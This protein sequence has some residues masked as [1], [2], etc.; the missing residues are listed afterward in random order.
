MPANKKIKTDNNN[1]IFQDIIDYEILRS[2]INYLLVI[3]KNTSNNN[4]NNNNQYI[5][6]KFYLNIN[7]ILNYTLVSKK[8]YNFISL[9]ISNNIIDNKSF[10]HWLKIDN[11]INNKSFTEVYN[12]Q[13]QYDK[14][15]LILNN[16]K[17]ISFNKEFSIIKIK[18]SIIDDYFK[19]NLILNRITID[20][21]KEI[22]NKFKNNQ[23]LYNKI[24]IYFQTDYGLP[25]CI[26][27]S[28]IQEYVSNE[29]PEIMTNLFKILELNCNI[30]LDN[31]GYSPNSEEEEE[32]EENKGN[33]KCSEIYL[34]HILVSGFDRGAIED[35]ETVKI[36]KIFK[37][38]NLV[39]DASDIEVESLSHVNY[40]A[41]FD[42]DN[43]GQQVESI[44]VKVLLEPE[45]EEFVEARHLM[46]V[47]QF[48]NL[49]S[50][51]I[52]INPYQIL[53]HLSEEMG[54]NKLYDNR[55]VLG[56]SKNMK[57]ELNQMIN[58]LITCKSLKNLNIKSCVNSIRF[59]PNDYYDGNDDGGQEIF[60][61]KLNE[62]IESYSNSFQPLFSELNTS[63][64]RIE[65]DCCGLLNIN[66][67]SNLLNNKSIKY[68]YLYGDSDFIVYS[69]K[70]SDNGSEIE[71]QNELVGE[72]VKEFKNL[73][74][75]I[76]IQQE[77]Q[78]QKSIN[79]NLKEIK[80][81]IKQHKC[82]QELNN[83]NNPY[84]TTTIDKIAY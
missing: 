23:L 34:N 62:A 56:D 51:S 7:E 27:L 46:K 13:N 1:K 33:K 38:K 20:D 18:E 75:N 41:L 49:H 61:N 68:L 29:N 5:I 14:N 54:L 77:E 3:K 11:N 45:Y 17:I 25:D 58:S 44:K 64:E 82:I 73:I 76:S 26:D 70:L 57:S 72:F 28:E 12:N 40:S 21:F 67:F 79:I 74:N 71:N 63:I 43:S 55:E 42:P 31:E 65:F 37:G 48:E 47:N 24:I 83:I 50:I 69:S 8:W 53:S 10:E 22:K 9:T 81:I 2:I 52:P 19:F 80:I 84:F 66:T 6:N 36:F 35:E 39:Y 78:Q 16:R 15:N 60:V 30:W 4:N 59:H 32:E